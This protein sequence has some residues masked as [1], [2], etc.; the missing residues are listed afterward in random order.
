[1]SEI[2]NFKL[3]QSEIALAAWRKGLLCTHETDETACLTGVFRES[4]G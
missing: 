4:R 2:C 1:M 3:V